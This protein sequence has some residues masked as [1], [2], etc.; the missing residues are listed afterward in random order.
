MDVTWSSAPESSN[1]WGRL[2][3]ALLLT[4]HLLGPDVCFFTVFLSLSLS[5]PDF[6]GLLSHD[7][8]PG[9]VTEDVS[10]LSGVQEAPAESTVSA[11]RTA[12]SNTCMLSIS[13]YMHRR[14]K[15][16][17]L[18]LEKQTGRYLLHLMDIT[19]HNLRKT[20]C[21]WH[22]KLMKDL[23]W[24]YSSCWLPLSSADRS[25]HLCDALQELKI[26]PLFPVL[27]FPPH[28]LPFSLSPVHDTGSVPAKMLTLI[29]QSHS[30]SWFC[31]TSAPG[32]SNTDL[33]LAVKS[34]QVVSSMP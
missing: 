32:I 16:Y 6:L 33:W 9:P 4:A 23:G 25:I 15:L 14:E 29:P 2:P 11:Q 5:P 18:C 19:K 26:W 3:S 7:C 31:R 30:L 21:E 24:G 34:R 10:W 20:V 17:K 22:Q 27:F 13:V 1:P 12:H 28:S 8:A